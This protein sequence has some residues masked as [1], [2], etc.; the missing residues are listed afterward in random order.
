MEQAPT[1]LSTEELAIEK[2]RKSSGFW[3]MSASEAL[4]VNYLTS[5]S[6]IN[7]EEE[8]DDVIIVQ[9]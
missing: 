7:D 2:T 1:E 6:S 5:I 8:I 9:H 3:E 4:E